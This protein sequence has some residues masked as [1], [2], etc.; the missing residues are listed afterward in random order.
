VQLSA[1]DQISDTMITQLRLL[2][3]GLSLA[4]FEIRFGRTP[5]AVYGATLTQLI[6]W[7]LL[8]E[9]GGNL[10]LTERGWFL[11]NQVFHRLV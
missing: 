10:L 2:Q 5:Y 1:E 8:K 9:N 3:E 6:D 11:S 7:G 4:D